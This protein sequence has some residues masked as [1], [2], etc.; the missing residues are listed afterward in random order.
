MADP[1]GAKRRLGAATPWAASTL[2]GCPL[3]KGPAHR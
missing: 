1:P 2:S 3:L